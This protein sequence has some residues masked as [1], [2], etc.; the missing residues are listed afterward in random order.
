MVDKAGDRASEPPL[1]IS[2]PYSAAQVLEGYRGKGD[3]ADVGA[4]KAPLALGG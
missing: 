2:D 1:E 4:N 3:I